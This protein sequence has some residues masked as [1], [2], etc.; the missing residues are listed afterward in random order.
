MSDNLDEQLRRV[1]RFSQRTVF[2]VLMTAALLLVGG[3]VTVVIMLVDANTRIE[4]TCAFMRDVGSAPLASNGPGHA[5]TRLG[6]TIV[7]DSHNAY[8][9]L[10]CSPA[11]AP[12]ATLRHWAARYGI[13]LRS[14]R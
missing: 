3:V 11:I 13:P 7:A 1:V 14:S 6:V 12:D 5:P 4:S 2:V 9:G 8:L 10:G